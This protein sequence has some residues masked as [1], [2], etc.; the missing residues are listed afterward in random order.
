M[1]EPLLLLQ[2]RRLK[3][4]PMAVGSGCARWRR[5]QPRIPWTVL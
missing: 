5:R 2:L 1:E 3:E 4:R